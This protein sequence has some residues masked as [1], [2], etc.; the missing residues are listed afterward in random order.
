LLKL[1]IGH[2]TELSLEPE[3]RSSRKPHSS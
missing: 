1:K 3:P 2:D